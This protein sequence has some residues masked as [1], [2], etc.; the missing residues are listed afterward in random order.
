MD[1]RPGG[2]PSYPYGAYPP[3]PAV[4]QTVAKQRNTLGLIAL[5]VSIVGFIFACVPGALIVGW[6]LLPI[7][8]VLGIVGVCLSGKTK[9]T[10]IAA[11]IVSIVGVVVG[12]VV[13]F[14][15]VTD[16]FS[17]A[18]SESDMSAPSPSS[19]TAR[20]D[21]GQAEAGTRENPF[22]I[23]QPVKNQEWEVIVGAPREAWAEIAAEN[24]F[25]EPAQ[26]GME[27]WLVPV[28]ATYTGNDTGS[29]SF[30]V[31]VEFV[32]SDN[33]TYNERC[34]VIPAPLGDVGELYKGGVAEGNICVAVPA[35]ADGLWTVSTGFGD[36]AFFDA[37]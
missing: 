2:A 21:D 4:P 20:D 5:I 12:V 16:A 11:I 34:G 31:N 37:G 19:S 27:Y 24:Q 7:G 1:Q 25:N 23:G 35:G 26:A 3:Y 22:P 29:P 9:G 13:F 15:V 10:S 28:T 32:G 18:F 33:R 17:D 6:V 8:F 30:D 14:T 36:P